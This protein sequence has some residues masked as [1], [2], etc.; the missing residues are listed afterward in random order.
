MRATSTAYLMHI[1]LPLTAKHV[2]E[3][4]FRMN[5]MWMVVVQIYHVIFNFNSG[6]PKQSRI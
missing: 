6:H 2:A 5:R 3:L 1:I 4:V